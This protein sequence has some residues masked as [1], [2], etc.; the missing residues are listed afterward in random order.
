MRSSIRAGSDWGRLRASEGLRSCVDRSSVCRVV[1]TSGAGGAACVAA[2]AHDAGPRPA[3]HDPPAILQREQRQPRHHDRHQR[4][5]A[6][7]IPVRYRLEPLQRPLQSGHLGR[8]R[9]DRA[10]FDGAQ[11][12]EPILLLRLAA[13]LPGQHRPD[14]DAQLLCGGGCGG[15]HAGGHPLRH[16][17]LS[18]LR[19]LPVG[20][21]QQQYD[22]AEISGL[23][24]R[25]PAAAPLRHLLRHLRHR[26]LRIDV[27]RAGDPGG[28]ADGRA[29]RR[30]RVR[31]DD[32]S[33]RAAPRL[34]RRGQWSAQSSD[35]QCQRRVRTA[36]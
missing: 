35:L 29:D 1:W 3:P 12:P 5:R 20:K 18:D 24:R 33:G 21:Q 10:E 2:S 25:H 7:A 11:G 14:A 13:L 28:A 32:R 23:V 8:R 27:D 15:S 34:R 17:G 31:P 16:P 22:H 36:G 4:R 30:R 6:S 19:R 26:Q 9:P